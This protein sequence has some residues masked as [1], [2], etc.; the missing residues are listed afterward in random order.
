MFHKYYICIFF[1]LFL[2]Y[3]LTKLKNKPPFFFPFTAE[4]TAW[5]MVLYGTST[6]PSTLDNKPII[7]RPLTRNITVDKQSADPLPDLV[8]NHIGSSGPPRLSQRTGI[9][10]GDSRD[11]LLS[12]GLASGDPRENVDVGSTSC[13]MSAPVCLGLCTLLILFVNSATL[14]S[15]MGEGYCSQTMSRLKR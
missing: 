10:S 9:T 12:S 6:P 4:T 2:A 14:N 13:R 15:L 5:S 7:K 3:K 8:T 1:F 11:S